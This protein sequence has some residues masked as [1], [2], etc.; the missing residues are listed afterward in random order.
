[1]FL[2]PSPL[3][4]SAS[5]DFGFAL[6]SFHDHVLKDLVAS[7]AAAAAAS[8]STNKSSSAD[9]AKASSSSSAPLAPPS[10]AQKRA[11]DPNSRTPTSSSHHP[12]HKVMKS[13]HTTIPND[14]MNGVAIILVPA[15]VTSILCGLNCLEFL[16]D[17][18]YVSVEEKRRLGARREA[19]IRFEH[20]TNS[21]KRILVRVL[22]TGV[23]LTDQEWAR[24]V[25]VFVQ[26]QEWQF[27]GW[28][29]PTPV[30]L[31]HNV[32]GFHLML[33]D[34]EADPKILSWNCRVLKVIPLS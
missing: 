12:P 28:K 13:S 29:W 23:R 9:G 30:E 16:R 7:S 11:L 26:G 8:A 2:S 4:L 33:D 19:E 22:D 34:R 21:G 10:S 15:A 27:K 24:V 5:K 32:L 6:Q 18:K 17:G 25:G 20:H 14:G 3:F 1:M 31:F